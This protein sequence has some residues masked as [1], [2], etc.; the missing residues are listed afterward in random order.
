MKMKYRTKDLIKSIERLLNKKMN[1]EEKIYAKQRII[2]LIKLTNNN[3]AEAYV[4]LGKINV[5]LEQFDEAIMSFN[6]AIILDSS[7]ASPHYELFNI[8]IK[9][10]KYIEALEHITAYEIKSGID[11]NICINILKNHLYG[12]RIK[13]INNDRILDLNGISKPIL[14]NYKLMVRAVNNKD[15]DK[16]IKHVNVCIKLIEKNKYNVDLTIIKQILTSIKLFNDQKSREKD[17]QELTEAFFSSNNYGADYY[18]LN[19]LLN[20]EPTNIN[21]LIFVIEHAILLYDFQ[22]A[23]ECL[24]IAE[25]IIG[26]SNKRLN[27]LKKKIMCL[28]SP[29]YLGENNRVDL[30]QMLETTNNVKMIEEVAIKGDIHGSIKYGYDLFRKTND[31]DYLYVVAKAMYNNGYYEASLQ[32]FT[33]YI[34]IGNIYL[35]Q[36]Y[37]YMFFINKLNHNDEIASYYASLAYEL[38]SFI[39]VDISISDYEQKLFSYVDTFSDHSIV[40]LEKS[41]LGNNLSLSRNKKY[42]KV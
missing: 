41:I 14:L 17:I 29:S 28:K 24:Q 23:E 22:K 32:A 37:C 34:S 18:I 13:L 8:Y 2:D 21:V 15:Y 42:L 16:A 20:I 9:Q 36:S 6:Q 25:V 5:V 40:E 12:N 4:F 31:S 38:S 10:F 30:K 27:Y 33:D 19:K 35:K 39:G 26:D 3:D 7:L 11:C 1:Y